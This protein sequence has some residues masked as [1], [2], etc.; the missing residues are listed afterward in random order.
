MTIGGQEGS[1][2]IPP[3]FTSFGIGQDSEL[4]Q[5]MSDTKNGFLKRGKA[6]QR[7]VVVTLPGKK[8]ALIHICH[9]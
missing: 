6:L 3:S 1:R 4:P 9:H 5:C 8:S 2:P 7:P